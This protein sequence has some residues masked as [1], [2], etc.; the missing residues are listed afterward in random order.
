MQKRDGGN[1]SIQSQLR[2]G[3]CHFVSPDPPNFGGW[4][5]QPPNWGM[6]SSPFSP[7]MF[8]V[9]GEMVGIKEWWVQKANVRGSP[10]A[11]LQKGKG[12]WGHKGG[13]TLTKGIEKRDWD[14]K[15]KDQKQKR[16]KG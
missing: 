5:F 3:L 8:V 15:E 1:A 16:R 13:K 6:K 14:E 12:M 9:R 10:P 11:I 4:P 2:G 7:T